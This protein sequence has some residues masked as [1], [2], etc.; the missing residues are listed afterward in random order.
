M[1]MA[2][3]EGARDAD[4]ELSDIVDANES[5]RSEERKSSISFSGRS[6]WVICDRAGGDDDAGLKKAMSSCRVD[7]CADVKTRC[8]GEESESVEEV[9]NMFMSNATRSRDGE[10]GPDFGGTK[11][12]I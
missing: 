2:I 11:G 9:N 5:S 1:S 8:R 4:G 6:A 12:W 3:G 10:D 7:S